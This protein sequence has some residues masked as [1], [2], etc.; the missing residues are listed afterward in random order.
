[1]GMRK[2]DKAGKRTDLISPW[3]KGGLAMN[4]AGLAAAFGIGF[5]GLFVVQYRLE[6]EE[7]KLLQGA[8]SV[9]I[10]V[11]V[12]VALLDAEEEREKLTEVQLYEAV[13]RLNN[14]T[15]AY[16]HEPWEGQLSMTEALKCGVEWIEYFLLPYMENS[17]FL[18]QEQSVNC[19]LWTWQEDLE[20]DERALLCSYWNVWINA[21]EL[22]AQLTLQASSG[23]VLQ[24][25]VHSSFL[26]ES[27]E[28]D[29]LKEILADYASSFGLPG[30]TRILDGGK[31]AAENTGFWMI[32]S[33]GERGLYAS[34]TTS[35]IVISWANPASSEYKE[36]FS[37]NLSLSTGE[38]LGQ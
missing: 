9:E 30:T 23:Q 22:E 27:Q 6:Q 36:I 8:G 11:S 13:Q 7:E 12:G 17:D 14:G 24:A 2:T 29:G 35:S 5:G 3:R 28:E 19:Y 15:E 26:E 20:D 4:L 18:L 32:Q 34:V 37:M 16:P 1:M 31:G 33:V 25:I 21:P 38:G 10:P